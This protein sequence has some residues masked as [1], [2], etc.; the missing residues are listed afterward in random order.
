MRGEGG[1]AYYS[2]LLK[3]ISKTILNPIFVILLQILRINHSVTPFI[4]PFYYNLA[5]Q[6]V[7]R[8]PL[9]MYFI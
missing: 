8:N 6:F 9:T 3:R 5:Q 2:I 1:S 7:P 4:S